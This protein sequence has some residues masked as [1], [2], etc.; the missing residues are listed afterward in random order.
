MKKFKSRILTAGPSISQKEIDYV[1]DAVK[2]GWNKHYADYTHRFEEGFAKYS[3]VKFALTTSGGTGALWL[4]LAAL[5]VGKGDEVII[6]EITYFACSDVVMLLGAKPV[7]VDILPDTWCIDPEKIEKAITKR[8]KAIMPVHI[9]GNLCELDEIKRIS[10][11]LNIPIVEDACPA[12]GSLYRGQK[13]GSLGEAGAFSFQGAKIMVT[14]FGGMFV[15][16]DKKLYEKVCYLN[17]HGEDPKKKF[18]QTSVG[19]TFEM[20]NYAAAL[21]L[22]QLERI[23]ELV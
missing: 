10:Q 18:W 4:S 5:G 22:A 20:P 3:G 8:T 13:P 21:G 7:F 16:N 1:M 17:N 23:E 19:Y 12:I 15:T 6:P 9:Y 2:T 14:G 11:K